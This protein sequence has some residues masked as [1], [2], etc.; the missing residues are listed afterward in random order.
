MFHIEYINQLLVI[1]IILS[2]ITCT[3]VQKTKALLP[4]SKS[5]I[6][7]SLIVNIVIGILFCLTFTDISIKDSIWIGL[8]TFLGANSIYRTLEGKIS[9]YTDIRNNKSSK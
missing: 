7:Y 1:S 3:L 4:N 6:I 8:F 2:S 5:V 9:S